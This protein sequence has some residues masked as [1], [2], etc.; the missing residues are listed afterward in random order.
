MEEST[1]ELGTMIL[2]RHRSTYQVRLEGMRPREIE[3]VSYI[4][5]FVASLERRWMLEATETTSIPLLMQISGSPAPRQNRV[6]VPGHP[7]EKA[8][9]GGAAGDIP[10]EQ[11]AASV[12]SSDHD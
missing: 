10:I 5:R 9:Q 1:I 8:Q 6:I 12:S 3:S 11:S 7:L 2:E 4:L